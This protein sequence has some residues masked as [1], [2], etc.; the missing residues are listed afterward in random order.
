MGHC[1]PSVQTVCTMQLPCSAAAA[2]AVVVCAWLLV[3]ARSASGATTAPCHGAMVVVLAPTPYYSF[4]EC[5]KMK[6]YNTEPINETKHV[7]A[8][9]EQ[10]HYIITY[11]G[12]TVAR[13]LSMAKVGIILL[14]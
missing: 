14:H 4:P 2:A 5:A 13:C 8:V 6:N 12:H 10:R 11:N 3:A 7:G 9:V 1:R